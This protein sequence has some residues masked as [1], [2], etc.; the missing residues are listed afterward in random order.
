MMW[1]AELRT[2]GVGSDRAAS[3]PTPVRVLRQR[4]CRSLFM[5]PDSFSHL[6]YLQHHVHHH[7]PVNVLV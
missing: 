7:L 2:Q 3:V 4:A 1:I 6:H 5:L